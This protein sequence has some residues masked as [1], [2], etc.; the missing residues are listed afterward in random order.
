MKIAIGVDHR[1][2]KLKDFL[3]ERTTIAGKK[4]TWLDQGCSSYEM[5]HYP[6]YARKVSRK[7]LDGDADAGLLICGSGVGVSIAANRHPGIYAGLV[8]NEDV[9]RMAKEDDNVNVLVLPA[10]FITED[11]ALVIVAAWLAA[12]FKGGVYQERISMID[13]Y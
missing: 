8:W 7:V 2:M 1:G 6:P 10:D 3:L 5:C 9:A 11:Q 4:I 13:Q 12:S